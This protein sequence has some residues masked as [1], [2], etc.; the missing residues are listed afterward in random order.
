MGKTKQ[1][2]NPPL[3]GVWSITNGLATVL[4]M[5]LSA[6]LQL[7]TEVSRDLDVVEL[8]S[9]VGSICG[10]AATA[11]YASMP[12][13]LHRVPGVT[14]VDGVD[15]EDISSSA[16]FLKAVMLTLR[17]REGGLL[18][19]GP[20]CSS[21]TFPNSSR[22]LRKVD[23]HWG[24]LGY[25]PVLVGNI[26]A[27][28]AMFLFQLALTRGVHCT[29]ENPPDSRIFHFWS[30]TCR[31]LSLLQDAGVCWSQTVHRCAYDSSRQPRLS[32]LYKFIGSWQGVKG[33]NARC[34]CN[35]IHRLT[36]SRNAEN[37]WTGDVV[38]LGESAAYPK[39]LGEALLRAWEKATPVSK[40][41]R[42]KAGE[43]LWPDTHGSMHLGVEA[44]RC[45]G[46]TPPPAKRRDF[47]GAR[48]KE[49]IGSNQ[50]AIPESPDC[51]PWGQVIHKA[52]QRLPADFG[53][54]GAV[55]N[56]PEDCGPWGAVERLPEDCRG[57]HSKENMDSKQKAIQ[58]SPDFGPWGQMINK[59][60]QRLPE[61]CGPW[62]AVEHVQEDCGPWGAMEQDCGPWG[63]VTQMGGSSR[64]NKEH[65]Q[66]QDCG[67]QDALEHFGPW[68]MV[69]NKKH[70]ELGDP[71]C[72]AERKQ[73]K[74]AKATASQN[75]AKTAGPWGALDGPAEWDSHDEFDRRL[76]RE[77]EK[78]SNVRERAWSAR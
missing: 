31:L 32:K 44:S 39:A 59:A 54:W 72:G 46:G 51:G 42:K 5:T 15:C 58:E 2:E 68:A 78:A 38:A 18:A 47:R 75:A 3:L 16:G 71:T 77:R 7:G 35:G 34:N 6:A 1:V 48:S 27:I 76:A 4:G 62:G 9:G 65:V 26:S 64:D 17:V 30:E 19:M 29:V 12:Y 25:K 63:A 74:T 40:E 13:D 33:L 49:N 70:Q 55:E 20:D 11:G 21:F 52:A 24:D 23:N 41:V 45:D 69:E 56:L 28:I 61:D 37:Q 36:G 22:H 8:W 60:V 67:P 14:D 43:S 73:L 50:K 10:A 66:M 57:A 53:P